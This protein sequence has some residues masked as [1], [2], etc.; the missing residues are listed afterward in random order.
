M[1]I[2]NVPRSHLLTIEQAADELGVTPRMIRRLT[3]SRQLPYVKVG[4]LV[5]I[6]QADVS[7]RVDAWT[8][9][10]IDRPG[11]DRVS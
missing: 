1:S 3:A 9:A 4:R 7:D 2:S 10:A 11:Q 5:R 6:R 8:I